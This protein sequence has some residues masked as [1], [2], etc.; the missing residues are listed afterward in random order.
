[1]NR[2]QLFAALGGLAA[3]AAVPGEL[4]VPGARKIFLPPRTGWLGDPGVLAWSGTIEPVMFRTWAIYSTD[5]DE[6][7]RYFDYQPV[8]T[9]RAFSGE[10]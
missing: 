3:A 2:R 4:W 5:P 8:K 6:P 7:V 9:W 10:G 1:M